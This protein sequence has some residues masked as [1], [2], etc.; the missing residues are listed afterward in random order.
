MARNEL[1]PIVELRSTT[2]SGR[3]CATRKNR[4]NDPGRT[5][6]RTFDPADRRHIDFRGEAAGFPLLTRSTGTGNRTVERAD[7]HTHPA[8]AVEI[9]SMP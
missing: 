9:G 7:G 1:R 8:I 4:R 5:V 2:D 6:P 3:T